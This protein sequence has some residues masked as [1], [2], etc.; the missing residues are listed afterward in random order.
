MKQ[1]FFYL[2][3]VCFLLST[4]FNEVLAAIDTIDT[5]NQ[6]VING[7]VRIAEGGPADEVHYTSQDSHWLD[8][9]TQIYHLYGEAQL[10]YQN[11]TLDADY[12][13]LDLKNNKAFAQPLPNAEGELDGFPVFREGNQ[14]YHAN[15]IE[16]NFVTK[17][18]IVDGAF[19]QQA[20]VYIH[21]ERTKFVGR[22]DGQGASEFI[23]YQKG[24]LF[25]T[26]NHPEPHFGIRSSK[27]KVIPGELAVI[28]P[29]NLE[30][31][32]VPTPLWLP[33]GFFP[34]IEGER[35]GLI[36]PNDFEY[37]PQWGYGLSNVGYY[38][39]IND[40]IDAQVVGNIYMRG[41]WAIGSN[42]RYKKRYKYNGSVNLNY[43]VFKEEIPE[44]TNIRRNKS[45]S[46]RVNHQQDARAHPNRRLGGNINIETNQFSSLNYNDFNNVYNN[47]LSS[48]FSFSQTF[49]GKPYSLN[50][51]L[52]H[53]QNT[54]T[55]NMNVSFPNLDFRMN[56]IFPFKR[57]GKPGPEQWYE[58][59]SFRYSASYQN[60]FQSPDSLFLAPE[61]FES[62]RMGLRQSVSTN[63]VFRV[64]KHFNLTPSVNY[65][66]VWYIKELERKFLQDLEIRRDTTFNA[67]STEF[68]VTN[69]TLSYG[70]FVDRERTGF[71]TYRTYRANLNLNT[72]IFG[73]ARFKGGFLRGI[74]HVMKPN[75][76]LS[77]APDYTRE[78]LDYFRDVE[79]TNQM[80]RR[81]TSRYSKFENGIFGGPPTGGSQMLLNYSIGNTVEAKIYSKRDSMERNVNLLSNVNISGNYDFN[82]DSLNFSP[83]NIGGTSRLFGGITTVRLSLGYDF[84]SVNE[85]GNRIDQFYVEETGKPLRFMGA[86]IRFN[87]SM[88]VAELIK[89]LPII[90]EGGGENKSSFLDLVRGFNINHTIDFSAQP[91]DD[92]ESFEVRSHYITFRG[93]IPLS[94]NWD[95]NVR[96][97]DYNFIQKRM[98]YPDFGISRDLHCW[99][100]SLNWQPRRGTYNFTIAVKP[101]SMDFINV[102]YR[103]S[104]VDAFTS[105]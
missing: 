100:M 59:I 43:S 60:R 57:S 35:A 93:S 80:G 40:Y 77:F 37:S 48:N 90:G 6:S 63:A 9:T 26:C 73:T 66:E 94:E 58:K 102:P 1:L 19:T 27:Q 41:S 91:G 30:I 83:L 96:N 92:N 25:T 10:K 22:E 44:S 86:N 84:Y 68:F 64:G 20:D 42:I 17:K 76:G 51:S 70:D 7:S 88:S 82:K 99:T 95:I 39:P 18:G 13:F 29:S 89:K 62:S 97:L 55:G 4:P 54:R 78:R 5:D 101:G 11:L 98:N 79:F 56:Q 75:I 14:V 45:F 85:Q 12:I 53:S 23:I 36:F 74:R 61:F 15:R 32:G 8:N 69:D 46:L 16:Y 24:A 28:G 2:P 52:S 21:G 3:F 104:R 33:F 50:A 67:D 49:P 34:L 65:D 31:A 81:D 38:F 47:Q 72:Q 103:K 105:F 87:T 71:S